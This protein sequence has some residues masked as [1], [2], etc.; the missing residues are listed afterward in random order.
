MHVVRDVIGEN[1]GS[2]RKRYVYLLS[3]LKF[4]A[5]GEEQQN[6]LFFSPPPS[7]N[8]FRWVN[9]YYIYNTNKFIKIL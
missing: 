6:S 9:A 3:P 5:F 2:K 7:F 1:L 8:L 4:C